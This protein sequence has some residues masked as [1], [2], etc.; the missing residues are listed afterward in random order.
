M[1]FLTFGA[2]VAFI[3]LTGC[4]TVDLSQVTVEK[5]PSISATLKKNVVERACI[6][7]ADV[8]DSKG[9]SKNK[10]KQTMQTATSILLHGMKK[11]TVP[12]ISISKSVSNV[13]LLSQDIKLAKLQI[14]QTTKAAEVHLVTLQETVT[15]GHELSLLETALISARQAE[16]NFAA[17]LIRANKP[18]SVREFVAFQHEINQL[19]LITNDYGVRM[20][21]QIASQATEGKS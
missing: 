3:S 10:P 2:I 5:Q 18:L 15:V 8:F 14:S 20:R 12:R 1:K 4:T 7:M 13:H 19:K 6:A 9:W 16:D 21:R 11:E 17:A